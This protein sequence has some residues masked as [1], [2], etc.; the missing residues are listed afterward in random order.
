MKG[1]IASAILLVAG[2]V[3]VLTGCPQPTDPTDPGTDTVEVG[4]V[5]AGGFEVTLVD[6][7]GGYVA[8]RD[9]DSDDDGTVDEAQSVVRGR[10]TNDLTFAAAR[11]WYLD[12]AVFIGNNTDSGNTL[13]IEAGTLIKGEPS[14]TNPGLL[15]ITR[16][17]E[18]NAAGTA[19]SPIVFTSA[20]PAGSRN[21]GDWGGIVINGYARVQG[22]TAEGEGSTGTYGGLNDDD[23]SG[24]L[25]YVRVEFAG[26]LFSP[27]NELNG[28]AF[29]GVGAGTTVNHIQVHKNGDDGIEFF[30]GSVA[31][32]NVVLT[33]TQDDALD[34]DDGWNG[35]AQF[36]IIHNYGTG[37]NAI[38]ADGDAADVFD[39]ADP[40]L[41]NFTIIGGGDDGP[42]FKSAAEGELWNSILVDF[43][44]APVALTEATGSGQPTIAYAG[45]A[46]VDNDDPSTTA[47]D[48][49]AAV[50]GNGNFYGTTEATVVTGLDFSETAPDYVPATLGGATAQTLPTADKHGNAITVATY[51]GAINVGGTDWTAG[52][53]AYPA[54]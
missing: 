48:W 24:T 33:G 14:T 31:V 37:G 35:S 8:Q 42:N 50:S 19:A 15:V 4:D 52:W 41:A 22:N 49:A 23:S 26:K 45:V 51:L 7:A 6:P 2:V 30:G 13:T 5:L 12:G 54:N 28:I 47:A 3:L 53:T 11:V 25:T 38:E 29:Q 20:N 17:S 40:I 43:G 18:I 34:Y 21:P 10:F 46:I 39:P 1:K 27:D 9:F 44:G 32:K 16:G 36:V